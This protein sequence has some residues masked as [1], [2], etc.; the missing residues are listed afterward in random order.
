MNPGCIHSK[1]DEASHQKIERKTA[2]A[3]FRHYKNSRDAKSS[4]GQRTPSNVAA[5]A[6]GYNKNGA[7][8]VYDRQR[9][10]K[11]AQAVWNARSQQRQA[12]ND[13][14]GIGRHDRAPTSLA[15]AAPLQR[16]I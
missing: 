7:D 15:E 14:R 6:D 9:Q 2:K 12:S 10:Q 16:Q 11:H 5:V 3:D 4:Q 1:P 8:V 13:E